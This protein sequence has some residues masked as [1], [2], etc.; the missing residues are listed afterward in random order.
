MHESQYRFLH[1]ETFLKRQKRIILEI[2]FVLQLYTLL[3]SPFE[4]QIHSL[5][6][7]TFVYRLCKQNNNYAGCFPFKVPLTITTQIL[8]V[9]YNKCDPQC[10]FKR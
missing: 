9:F 10:L 1:D 3:Q 2:N 6:L 7:E 8:P 4:G 5:Q